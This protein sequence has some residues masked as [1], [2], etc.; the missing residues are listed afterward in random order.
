MRACDG[1]DLQRGRAPCR[2][3]DDLCEDVENTVL[4]KS[5]DTDCWLDLSLLRAFR[6]GV[7]ITGMNGT[8]H[9]SQASEVQ[10]R[11]VCRPRALSGFG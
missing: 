8:E 7:G 2:E 3:R 11:S 4:A 5:T 10:H 6:A 9:S 1:A